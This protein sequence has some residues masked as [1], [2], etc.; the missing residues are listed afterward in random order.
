MLYSSLGFH[1][2]SGCAALEVGIVGLPVALLRCG[3]CARL[4]H[5]KMPFTTQFSC[6]LPSSSACEQLS[7]GHFKELQQYFVKS[8][9]QDLFS[10]LLGETSN[11]YFV[12]VVF[13]Y[14]YVQV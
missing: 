2:C 11:L 14:K 12:G 13:I 1:A 8:S 6:L 5:S 7:F 9:L 10:A 3:H 4:L